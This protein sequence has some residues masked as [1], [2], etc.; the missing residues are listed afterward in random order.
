MGS[1]V[2]QILRQGVWAA[3]S[4]GW[5]QDPHQGA[6][7]NALHLYLWLFLLGFPFTLYMYGLPAFGHFVIMWEM[8]IAQDSDE[9]RNLS[10]L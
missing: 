2:V 3:L 7:V 8:K 6:G 9:L 5:Y 10:L 1:Q 4:G